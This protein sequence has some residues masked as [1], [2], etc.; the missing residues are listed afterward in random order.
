[1]CSHKHKG[2]FEAV[3]ALKFLDKF[4]LWD[5]YWLLFC[6]IL[7]FAFNIEELLLPSLKDDKLLR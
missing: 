5:F 6:N 1:M 4:A 2:W 7:E 3:D